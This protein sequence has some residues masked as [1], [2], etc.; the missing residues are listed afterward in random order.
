MILKHYCRSKIC[1]L[2]SLATLT[3]S[4]IP[5]SN[6]HPHTKARIVFWSE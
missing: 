3:P 5:H 6:I 1:R 4:Q 2:P